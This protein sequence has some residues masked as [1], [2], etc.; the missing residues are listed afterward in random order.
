LLSGQFAQNNH[1][2]CMFFG[3]NRRLDKRL[4]VVLS[5]AGLVHPTPEDMA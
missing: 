4:A 3:L 5:A 2:P 1:W